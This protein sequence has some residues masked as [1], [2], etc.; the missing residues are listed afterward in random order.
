MLA[1]CCLA[2]QG[3]DYC[4]MGCIRGFGVCYDVP[5]Q[6]PIDNTDSTEQEQEDNSDEVVRI[7]QPGV[8]CMLEIQPIA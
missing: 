7:A 4:G 8:W 2:G 5:N 6:D 3:G 1:V